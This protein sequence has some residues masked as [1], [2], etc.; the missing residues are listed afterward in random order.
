MQLAPCIGAVLLGASCLAAAQ[1]TTIK[2]LTLGDDLRTS[3]AKAAL[4]CIG[5]SKSVLGT[6]C[7]RVAGQLPAEFATLAGQ[8]V[9][10]L[11]MYG[12]DGNLGMIAFTL[13]TDSYAAA[14]DAI[15]A[16]FGSL[17]CKSSTV[18]TRSGSELDQET[19]D[20]T[21]AAT[22]LRMQ[23]RSGR[24]DQASI[25]LMSTEYKTLSEAR[26]GQEKTKNKSDI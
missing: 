13:P 6:G 4:E 5:D 21:T 25:R 24:I 26:A 9:L 19:C 7:H 16:R 3:A 22:T 10:E 18:R 17:N 14:K 2:G 12:I 8:P 1:E 11:S 15:G 23:K 20:A